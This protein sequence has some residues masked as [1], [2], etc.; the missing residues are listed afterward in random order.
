MLRRA[1][2]KLCNNFSDRKVPENPDNLHPAVKPDF[3][4]RNEEDKALDR[5]DPVPLLALFLNFDIKLFANLEGL[6]P[7][8]S[9]PPTPVPV[10]FLRLGLPVISRRSGL[11]GG[12]EGILDL[13][14]HCGFRQFRLVFKRCQFGSQGRNG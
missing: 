7:F 13:F 5:R 11:L 10:G 4:A 9:P 12:R 3:P 2:P 6:E 14:I 1:S 8:E